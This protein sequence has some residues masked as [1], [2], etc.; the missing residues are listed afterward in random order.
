MTTK[1]LGVPCAR[2]S[3][4]SVSEGPAKLV[5]ATATD[6][7]RCFLSSASFLAA[8]AAAAAAAA[9]CCGWSWSCCCCAPCAAGTAPFWQLSSCSSHDVHWSERNCWVRPASQ[10]PFWSAPACG[11][12]TCSGVWWAWWAALAVVVHAAA[13]LGSCV[14][15][16]ALRLWPARAPAA[17]SGGGGGGVVSLACGCCG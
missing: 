15:A 16:G 8:A 17:G 9:G 1:P 14:A 11:V 4:I 5:R 10:P 13:L 2:N 12:A 7:G 6:V 3:G